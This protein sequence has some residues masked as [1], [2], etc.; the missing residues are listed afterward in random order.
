MKYGMVV[1]LSKCCGCMSCDVAC[2]REHFTPPGVHWSKVH[3]YETGTYPHTKLRSLPT[4]CM[5][6]EEPACEKACPT[7]ATSKRPDG[8]VTIDNDRCVGCG[9]CAMACPYEARV[10]NTTEP[11]PYH[12]PHDFTPFEKIGYFQKLGP[13]EH[14]KGVIE[15]CTFC[16]HRLEQDGQ[17]AC[18]EGCPADAR[19]FGDL[20]DAESEVAKLVAGGAEARLEEHGTS[21]KVHYL[22]LKEHLGWE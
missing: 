5:H 17:P 10:L 3:I 9:Y 14:G 15:K 12:E 19:V 21:P 1:D 8:V 6:C 11:R 13:V 2:K 4:L 20:D 18:V 16:L 22:H 7:G